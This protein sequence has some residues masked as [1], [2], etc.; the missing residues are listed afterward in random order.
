MHEGRATGAH[1][2]RI[3]PRVRVHFHPTLL[4]P[5][6]QWKDDI[7]AERNAAS[8]EHPQMH[9]ARGQVRDRVHVHQRQR[10]LGATTALSA[11]DESELER[12]SRHRLSLNTPEIGAAIGA[13]V[14]MVRGAD[15]SIRRLRRRD[16]HTVHLNHVLIGSTNQPAAIEQQTNRKEQRHRWISIRPR[17]VLCNMCFMHSNLHGMGTRAMP[18]TR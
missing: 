4:T 3:V 17:Y 14:T 13:D 1:A 10:H 16:G 11:A 2:N 7:V 18:G 5:R 15:R 12:I 8:L 9:R 6:R